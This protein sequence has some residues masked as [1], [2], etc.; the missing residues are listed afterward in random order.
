M[1]ACLERH[2]RKSA[3]TGWMAA[4]PLAAVVTV[5]AAGCGSGGIARRGT[6]RHAGT[7]PGAASSTTTAVVKARR[8]TLRKILTNGKGHAVYL[9]EMDTGTKPSCYG[10]CAT[11]WPPVLTTGHPVAGSA[12]TAALP[13][14][15]RRTNGTLQVTYAGHPLYYFSADQKPSDISGEGTQDFGGG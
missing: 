11:A 8:S 7:S 5:V 14:T 12:I 13:G 3:R 1:R 10:A 15:V 9:F 4:I 6:T 2:E